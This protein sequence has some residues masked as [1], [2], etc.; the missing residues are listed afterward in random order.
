MQELIHHENSRAEL[1]EKL[2]NPK[3]ES[4]LLD[5]EIKSGM[6]K[7]LGNNNADLLA[8]DHFFISLPT[9][10]ASWI[11]QEEEV[12]GVGTVIDN[13]I[14]CHFL[15]VLSPLNMS[16]LDNTVDLGQQKS[17]FFTQNFCLGTTNLSNELFGTGEGLRLLQILR[18]KEGGIR[19]ILR[20][21]EC[22]NLK[23]LL[24]VVVRNKIR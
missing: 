11:V 23:N 9:R 12:G 6:N 1:G 7:N 16:L 3:V 22:I 2:V 14:I 17:L 20:H 21:S 18:P 19:Y 24:L 8:L 4:L 10:K 15:V 5:P 13:L